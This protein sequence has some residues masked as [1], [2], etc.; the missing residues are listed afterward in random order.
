[1]P[2]PGHSNRLA[3]ETSPYLRQHA[4]NPVDWYPWGEEALA[5]ARRERRPI[6][7]SIGYAACH[8][9]H[10][11]AHESFEDEATAALMNA[12][13][14]NIKV[15]REERPDLDRLYQLAHQMLA[16]RGGGWPLTMFLMHEDQRPFFGGT[17]FPPQARHGLPSFGELL[18]HVAD[19]YRDHEAELRDSALAVVRA[20]DELQPAPMPGNQLLDATPLRHCRAQMERNFDRDWGGFGG[21]PKFPHA[22]LVQRALRDWHASV[23]ADVPDLQALYM[24][25]LTLTRM[26]EGGL[27]DQLGGGFYRYSVDG[28]WA[29]PHFEKMLY[30]NAL[31][32]GVYAEAACATGEPLFRQVAGRTADWMLAELRADGGAFYSSLDADAA[33]VE[34]SYYVWTNAEVRA[35]LSPDEYAVF[36][37]HHG[38]DLPPNFEHHAHHLIVAQP[39]EAIGKA[40]QA[41][42]AG[43]AQLAA[44]LESARERLLALRARRVRPAR[45]EK[46]LVSWNALAIRALATAARVLDRPDLAQAASGALRYLRRQHWRDGRLLAT[47]G[48]GEARLNAYLDDY[49]FLADAILELATVRFDGGELRFAGEL[50]DVVLGAFA[51]ERNGGFYFTSADHET[52]ISR[53]KSFGDEALPAGNGIAAV[54]LQRLGFLLG[55]SR[56]LEAAEGTLRAAWP[57]MQEYPSGHA[58]L[59]QALEETLA[60][61]EIV[62]LRGPGEVIEGWRRQL[63]ALYAPRRV[64]L[65]IASP[66][67]TGEA[68]EALPAAFASKPALPGGAAYV[69]RGSQC[70][71]PLTSLAALLA[72]LGQRD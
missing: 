31:L 9:C 36:A 30:D 24:A 37:A 29:I 34:G 12:R 64:V 42:P 22:P 58:S 38:L 51:D 6:L 32:L 15:D 67:G 16:R 7:L 46:I 52:L 54:V 69:C 72:E 39:L 2:E 14:V 20:L 28:Q 47:S 68:A 40:G 49:L 26:A 44:L 11:M 27:F 63:A 57:A 18:T 1:M 3:A 55:E 60:P 25:T 17:Y 53:P 33:G 21:A 50:L 56:Y 48:G 65:A 70:S 10:V 61:T 62:I 35:A 59:L 45:D 41:G 71:A 8:W 19:Y 43:P 66:T 4:L 13:F 23:G 5:L